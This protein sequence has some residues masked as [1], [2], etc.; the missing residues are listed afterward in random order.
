M[1]FR[2]ATWNGRR[3]HSRRIDPKLKDRY[4]VRRNARAGSSA[5]DSP[6]YRT[7]EIWCESDRGYG[8]VLPSEWRRSVGL[9]SNHVRQGRVLYEVPRGTGEQYICCTGEKLLNFASS[10]RKSPDSAKRHQ[11]RGGLSLSM[12]TSPGGPSTHC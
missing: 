8:E 4:A 1:A 2:F 9:T 12:E 5:S 6:G 7:P 10:L 3:I 11:G